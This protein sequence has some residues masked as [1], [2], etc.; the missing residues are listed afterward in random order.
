MGSGSMVPHS[1]L[2]PLLVRCPVVRARVSQRGQS[3]KSPARLG[4][5]AGVVTVRLGSVADVAHARILTNQDIQPG[6]HRTV[7]RVVAVRG[8]RAADEND[9]IP[10]AAPR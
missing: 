3:G 6:N 1:S 8:Q 5:V 7:H 4:H 10:I 2:I 9:A